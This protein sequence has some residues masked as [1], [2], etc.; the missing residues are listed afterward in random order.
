MDGPGPVLSGDAVDMHVTAEPTRK[1]RDYSF[2]RGLRRG[3]RQCSVTGNRRAPTA[4]M[5][6]SQTLQRFLSVCC[7][8]KVW[9]ENVLI[10]PLS[11]LIHSPTYHDIES[12]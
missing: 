4:F 3:L 8:L 6:L 5:L 11:H 7:S 12:I 9:V 1:S 10:P 2:A